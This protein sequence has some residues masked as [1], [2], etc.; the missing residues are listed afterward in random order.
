MRAKLDTPEGKAIYGKRKIIVE[1][2]FGQIK[3]VMG[4]T[5]F[6]LRGLAK[7]KGE[8][9]LVCLAHN[10]KKIASF[11]RKC[12]LGFPNLMQQMVWG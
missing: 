1:P 11:I 6:M 4:F 10:L 12:P 7:V 3:R 8:F 5:T 2:V 9:N